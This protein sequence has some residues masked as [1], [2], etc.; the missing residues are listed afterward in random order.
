M[1]FVTFV[2]HFFVFLKHRYGVIVQVV[3][4]LKG[5]RVEMMTK[6]K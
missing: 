4:L 3:N 2:S 5:V 1:N 6:D